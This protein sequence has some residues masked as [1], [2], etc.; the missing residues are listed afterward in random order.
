MGASLAMG[1]AVGEARD[2]GPSDE[3]GSCEQL[4]VMGGVRAGARGRRVVTYATLRYTR[5]GGGA[6]E[7]LVTCV[8]CVT[9][10]TSIT[11]VTHVTHA[12]AAVLSRASRSSA[13]PKPQR[14]YS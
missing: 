12:W 11:P 10:V 8:I 13:L 2:E 9:S 1:V 14:W 4:R 3:L 7:G 6:F 5:L